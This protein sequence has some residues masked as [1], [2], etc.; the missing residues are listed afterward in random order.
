MRYLLKYFCFSI[1]I[2]LILI[3]IIEIS[4]FKE[5]SQRATARAQINEFSK[6]LKYYKKYYGN[7]PVN[8]KK[9]TM[10]MI[11]KQNVYLSLIPVI[12]LDPWG[13]EYIY[14]VNYNKDK[15]KIISY[16]ADNKLGGH[17]KDK[18]IIR[19]GK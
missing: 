17:G 8:L 12:P 6:V 4:I 19:I 16:G 1:S 13:K 10:T 14:L 15:Y 11:K 5:K 2:L 9:L 7:Y 3:I 18:D